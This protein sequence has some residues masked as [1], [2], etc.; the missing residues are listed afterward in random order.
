[1]IFIFFN[2][3][4]APNKTMTIQNKND[5]KCKTEDFYRPILNFTVIISVKSVK[6]KHTSD[7]DFFD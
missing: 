2:K 5:S 4:I 1:M 3:Y 7:I 6:P